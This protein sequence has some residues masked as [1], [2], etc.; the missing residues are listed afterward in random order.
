MDLNGNRKVVRLNE[1]TEGTRPYGRKGKG[2]ERGFGS[3]ERTVLT[4]RQSGETV[5][6]Q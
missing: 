6:D 5:D 1:C 4:T 3:W 2:M